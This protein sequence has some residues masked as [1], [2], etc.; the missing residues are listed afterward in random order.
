LSHQLQSGWFIKC[1][2]RPLNM[3]FYYTSQYFDLKGLVMM[4]FGIVLLAVSGSRLRI[5]WSLPKILFLVANWASASL[6][7]ISIIVG[8][9]SSAFWIINANSLAGNIVTVRD[10]ARYPLDIFNTAFRRIFTFAAPIGFIAFYPCQALLRPAAEVSPAAWFSP[11]VGLIMF[12]IAYQIWRKGVNS[13][14]GTGS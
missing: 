9:M 4:V 5:A 10:F 13:H 6:I 12:G 14:S 8:T 7:L 3:M 11:A 2:F 1:Y